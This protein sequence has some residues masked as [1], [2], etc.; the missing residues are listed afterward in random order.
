M[1]L[2]L[3]WGCPHSLRCERVSRNGFHFGPAATE[4]QQQLSRLLSLVL[5]YF[6]HRCCCEG[7]QH[8]EQ[9]MV[10]WQ[11]ALRCFYFLFSLCSR[12]LL[13]FSSPSHHT[14]IKVWQLRCKNVQ[15]LINTAK[16]F[17]TY[18]TVAVT[19]RLRAVRH[20][21]LVYVEYK[22]VRLPSDPE[23]ELIWK[24]TCL[25]VLDAVWS[26]NFPPFNS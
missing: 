1:L 13:T 7:W 16:C 12:M 4:Q 20:M 10:M 5:D 9:T 25:K 15:L 8:A 19:N 2:R 23:L 14:D 21:I 18:S 24:P 26:F 22:V 17:M 3:A 6:R 11:S